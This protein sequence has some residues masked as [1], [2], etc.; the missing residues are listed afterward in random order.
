[1][2]WFSEEAGGLSRYMSQA[3]QSQSLAGHQVS[4]LV[5]GTDAI[6]ERSGGLARPFARRDT[7][8]DRRLLGMRRHFHEIL[9]ESPA[10][11]LVA[12]HFS[13]Y[14]RPILPDLRRRPWVM[15]F[16]G[17]WA[18][19]GAAE[20]QGRLVTWAKEAL[21]ER[22]L[23][24]AAP[25]LVT[26]SRFFADILV[27][28][29]G[30]DRTRIATIPGGFAPDPFLQAPG[31]SAARA[32]LGLPQ[33]RTILVCVR[34]LAA[35][36]GIENLLEAVSRLRADHPDILLVIAGKGP[37]AKTLASHVENADLSDAVRLLGFVPDEDL[38]SLYASADLSVV[39]T[40]SLEGFGLV[41]AESMAAGTPVVASRVGA[42]PE[43]L[44][45]FRDDLLAPPTPE[46]LAAT[47][48][49]ALGNLPDAD[50]CRL[51]ARQWSWDCVTPQLLDIY[52]GVIS[53]RSSRLR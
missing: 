33:D 47:L 45:S 13:L 4:A 6:R 19:E 39:P 5:T 48:R 8:L 30:I 16:H 24:R 42:L 10:P 52:Q 40:I 14:A 9:A 34:R 38:P 1:M 29:F 31:K 35:R 51:H 46:G 20:G 53:A 43:L 12:C 3:V 23:Y 18:M 28:R 36:M 41:V 25:R 21:I 15:H 27:E 17:P 44:G 11:D 49:H 26:L 2:G 22:P 37:L 32:R 50:S 7:R